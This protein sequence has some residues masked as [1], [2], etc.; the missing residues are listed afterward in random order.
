LAYIVPNKLVRWECDF[1]VLQCLTIYHNLKMRT[2][3]ACAD[4][5]KLQSQLKTAK[6]HLID[7]K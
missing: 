5:Q 3:L 4:S 1:L 6:V 2:K 7:L